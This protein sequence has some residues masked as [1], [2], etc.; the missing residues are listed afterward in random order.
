MQVCSSKKKGEK[1][2][3]D[4]ASDKLAVEAKLSY[5]RRSLANLHS[6]IV[7]VTKR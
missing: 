4:L 1:L 2:I 5:P 3:V 6:F 7:V